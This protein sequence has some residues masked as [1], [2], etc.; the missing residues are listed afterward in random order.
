MP[1]VA[2][3]GVAEFLKKRFPQQEW[4]ANTGQVGLVLHRWGRDASGIWVSHF[5]CGMR[6]DERHLHTMTGLHFFVC[7]CLTLSSFTCEI[8]S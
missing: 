7:V 1:G 2:P 6:E 5:R 3:V 4:H 8:E